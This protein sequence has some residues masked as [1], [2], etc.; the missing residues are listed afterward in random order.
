[1]TYVGNSRV[2]WSALSA[3][4]GLALIFSGCD[5]DTPEEDGGGVD[6]GGG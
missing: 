3:A 5:S 4:L 6:S 1:M 2:G